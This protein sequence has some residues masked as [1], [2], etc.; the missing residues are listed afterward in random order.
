MTAPFSSS[1]HDGALLTEVLDDE[2]ARLS[3]KL[4]LPFILFHLEGRSLEEIAAILG[5]GVSTIGTWLRRAREQLALRLSRRGI[6]LTAV[7][8]ATLSIKHS[9]EASVVRELTEVTLKTASSFATGGSLG[10]ATV[11]PG[12]LSFVN[13]SR[14]FTHFL[15]AKMITM[16]SIVMVLLGAAT[17]AVICL[18]PDKEVEFLQ[19]EWRLV[20]AERDGRETPAASFKAFNERMVVNRST[21]VQYQTLPDGTEISA[22]KGTIWIDRTTDPISIDIWTYRGTIHGIYARNGDTVTLCVTQGGGP[23]PDRFQ[24]R[25]GDQRMLQRFQRATSLSMENAE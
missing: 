4:R 13:R 25:Q 16:V 1:D 24:T 7:A 20:A 9:S 12:V 10:V 2:I 19:G 23:R 18:A 11:S 14:T 5:T 8:L 21:L 6:S 22:N 15:T 3:E 17:A